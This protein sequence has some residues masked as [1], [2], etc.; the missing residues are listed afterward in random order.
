MDDEDGE[1]QPATRLLASGGAASSQSRAW[2]HSV[3]GI[4]RAR[5][6]R[7]AAARRRV[8]VGE[9]EGDP[10]QPGLAYETISGC[11]ARSSNMSHQPGAAMDESQRDTLSL[12][13]LHSSHPSVMM[14]G[15]CSAECRLMP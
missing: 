9:P 1:V 3:F 13:S 10:L 8:G 14:S 11:G 5:L 15:S 6:S 4:N 7:S 2:L 12:T